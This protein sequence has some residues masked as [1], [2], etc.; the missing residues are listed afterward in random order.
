MS[1]RPL[2]YSMGE[3]FKN[4]NKFVKSFN[5]ATELIVVNILSNNSQSITMKGNLQQVVIQ[6]VLQ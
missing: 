6:I 3:N 5:F 2:N 1:T 4:R